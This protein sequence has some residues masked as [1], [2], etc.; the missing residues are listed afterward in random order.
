[1]VVLSSKPGL[2]LQI[3][4]VLHLSILRP[5]DVSEKYVNWLNDPVVTRYTEQRFFHHSWERVE[6]FVEEKF[7]DDKEYLFGIF[8]SGE[9]VGNVK[10]GP[11]DTRHSLSSVSYFIGEQK[12]WGKGIA[13]RAVSKAVEFAFSD[14]TLEKLT[15]GVYEPNVGS[16]IVLE[17]CG[18]KQEGRRLK[19]AI[20]DSQRIDTYEFGL[21]KNS[22][23]H[24]LS[25]D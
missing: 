19:H 20:Y 14:L 9:H 3:N 10:I 1:M 12:L 23:N 8:Y 11:I 21:L 2:L 18:F 17:K 7:L 4:E 5:V 22:W 25:A 6:A 13:T 16:R 24:Q 15:A